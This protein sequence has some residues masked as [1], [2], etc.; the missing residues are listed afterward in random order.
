MKDFSKDNIW[1]LLR[2]NISKWQLAGYAIANIIGLTVILTGILFYSNS[3]EK[4]TSDNYF[5][6][7]YIVISKKVDGIGFS[8]VT[9]SD[10]DIARLEAQPWVRK[11]GRFTSSQF[12][13]NAAIEMGGRGLSSY[14][15]FESVPDDFF[16]IKPRDWN[17]DPQERFVPIVLSKDYLTLYN[18]GFAI[19]QGLPQLSEDVIGAI[20]I[21]LRITGENNIPEYFDAAI[22]GFSSRLNTIA[23]PQSFMDWANDRYAGSTTTEA[24][25]LIIERDRLASAQMTEY[26][27]SEGIEIA[28]D[29]AEDGKLSDFLGLTSAVVTTNGAI[30]SILAVFILLL[31]IFLLIQKSREKLQ[32]LMLLGYTP[33]KLSRYYE[34]VVLVANTAITLISLTAAVC[35]SRLWQSTLSDIG[36]GNTSVMP[37]I[38]SALLYL[39]II[40]VVNI[41]TIRRHILKIRLS[42]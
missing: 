30:I 12:A 16:D 5:S 15:F 13:V 27:Q 32:N 38:V 42:A 39:T 26:L 19:P 40:T 17:F 41:I 33:K 23:V 7:D 9:F 14:L 37:A 25:R 28:G 36:L 3:R 4:D 18:F 11:T 34:R 24:S 31:S 21:R 1:K 6:N 29:K 22:V 20:P 2:R 35:I 8:P 10:S